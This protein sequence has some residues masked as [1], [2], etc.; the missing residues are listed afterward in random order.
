MGCPF[1]GVELYVNQHDMR[2]LPPTFGNQ[3][4][5]ITS[6]RSPCWME[7]AE[8]REPTWAL[9]PRNP[10]FVTVTF[11]SEAELARFNQHAEHLDAL[12][13]GRA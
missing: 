10:E 12:R 9:C 8:E 1:Y 7:V 6:A 11:R 3:C 2:M 4:A 5:L 13:T